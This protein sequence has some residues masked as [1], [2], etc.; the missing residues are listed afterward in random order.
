[1]SITAVS[2]RSRPDRRFHVGMAIILLITVVVG[3]AP[4]FY[5]RSAHTSIPLAPLVQ[6]HG[7]LFT[8]WMVLFVVQPALI[9]GGRTALHRQLGMFGAALAL[10]LFVIGAMTAIAAASRGQPIKGIDPLPFLAIP[11]ATILV[12]IGTVGAALW[13]RRRSDIH[14]RLMLIAT[15]GVMTPAIA[16]MNI[17]IG[18]LHGPPLALFLTDVFVIPC[19]IND[20]LRIGRIH[21][22]YL[23]G[24]GFLLFSQIARLLIMRT[25]AWIAVASWL[26]R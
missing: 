23:W 2:L 10:S 11:I 13:F 17:E 12:F 22:A 9:A 4:T 19:L 16:R 24:A 20:R 21:P 25:E 5:L 6:V 14:K 3:F 7:L 26:V 18:P 8:A 15:I 1:M